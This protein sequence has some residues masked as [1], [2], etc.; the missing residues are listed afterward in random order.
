MHFDRGIYVRR[1]N[2]PAIKSCARRCVPR[3]NS[4]LRLAGGFTIDRRTMAREKERV[5]SSSSPPLPPPPVVRKYY[6]SKKKSTRARGI[7]S[8]LSRSLSQPSRNLPR[9]RE[10]SLNSPRRDSRGQPGRGEGFLFAIRTSIRGQ[11]YRANDR[12]R[13]SDESTHI[14]L[15]NPFM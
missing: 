2:V 5:L 8:S 1:C 14:P 13:T 4:S 11:F 9:H 7:S 3:K 10:S 12:P 6:S 15:D